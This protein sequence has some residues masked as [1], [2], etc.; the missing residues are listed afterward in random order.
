MPRLFAKDK[1]IS[2]KEEASLFAAIDTL[3]QKQTDTNERNNEDQFAYQP[4]PTL[5]NNFSKGEL[6]PFD[7]NLLSMEGWK[8]LGLNDKTV[9]TI[10][11][12]G[13]F[14]KPEDLKK[15]WG[16]PDGFYDYVSGY[17]SID[18]QEQKT[19]K[20]TSA[21]QEKKKTWDININTADTLAFIALPGIG[22]KLAL[23][24]LNFRDKLGGF[25]SVEQIGETY[26]LPDSTFDKI[27]PFL[28]VNGEVDK[29]NINSCT[30]DDLKIHPYI[31]WTLAN[32]IVEYRNQHGSFK[33]LDDLRNI[34][35]VDEPTFNKIV[36][37]LSL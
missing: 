31:K 19:E 36:H 4:E 25:Y 22:N 6:F 3:N 27:K 13:K 37:Y 18:R 2:I 10:N 17:I 11:K 26:G 7:P 16:L 9:K 20:F 29:I 8:K 15:I 28:H 33:Q 14:Y 30:K 12:G 23:R 5:R 1:G 24:I 32:A 35:I 34:S 21:T